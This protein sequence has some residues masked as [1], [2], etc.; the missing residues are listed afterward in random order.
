MGP[1]E[2]FMVTWTVCCSEP[3]Y[4]ITMNEEQAHRWFKQAFENQLPGTEEGWNGLQLVRVNWQ[5]VSEV[6]EE[7]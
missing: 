7:G 6:M 2:W 3:Q 4:K 5:G 1:P